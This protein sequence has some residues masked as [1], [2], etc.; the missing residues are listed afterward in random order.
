MVYNLCLPS[1]DG[2]FIGQVKA[3]P[4]QEKYVLS[5]SDKHKLRLSA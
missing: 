1:D 5:Q 3:D 2:D 4:D